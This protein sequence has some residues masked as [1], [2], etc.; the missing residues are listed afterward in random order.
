MFNSSPSLADIAAVTGGNR[1]DGAW[2]DG[3]WWVLIILFALFGGWGG[4]GFG[5]NGGGGYT[6]TAAT[7]A[8][9]QRG[10]DNS[11]VISKLDGITNGLCDGFYAVNNGML[12]GFNSIQQAINADTVAGMQN[13]NAIQSQLANCCCETREAIQG[14]N[15]NMAQNTCALQNTMN[16]NTR[17]IIDSQNAG[18]RAILDYLCQDKIATLQAEN[19]DLRLAASQDRQNAL[20]TTAMT[21][22]TNHIISAVNPSP[23]PAYQVPNP[24]TYI[25]YGCG[26]NTGCGC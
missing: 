2:G 24:N 17:D 23:I 11:A 8:D 22:Q 14:V 21:A 7:Q 12:T 9:I 3:G 6:A 15:F 5:G 4:Y 10:F 18:T 13:A 19:N 25:P 16:N 20:L 26:C 1:N